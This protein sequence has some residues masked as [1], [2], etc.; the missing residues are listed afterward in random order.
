MN[1]GFIGANGFVA[2][3]F[4]K[5]YET[6]ANVDIHVFGRTSPKY[7]HKTYTYSD[8]ASDT[9]DFDQLGTFDVIF[10]LLGK[11]YSLTKPH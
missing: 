6:Q 2:Q 10:Y 7:R 8:L 3:A 5:F 1:I 9:V 4:G 11:A